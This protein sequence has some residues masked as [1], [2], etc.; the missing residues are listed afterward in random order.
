MKTSLFI[1]IFFSLC[2]F[3]SSFVQTKAQ[4]IPFEGDVERDIFGDGISYITVNITEGA[5][6]GKKIDAYFRTGMS[7]QSEVSNYSELGAGMPINMLIEGR[8]EVLKVKG[9]LIYTAATFEDPL[10]GNPYQN[11]VYRIKELFQMEPPMAAPNE[12]LVDPSDLIAESK[13]NVIKAWTGTY[14]NSQGAILTIKN[15]TKD[16]WPNVAVL[17]F[18][19]VLK[20]EGVCVNQEGE[21]HLIDVQGKPMND[22]ELPVQ[23]VKSSTGMSVTYSP[24]FFAKECMFQFDAEFIKK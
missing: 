6:K 15:S 7:D 21:L 18:N 23:F 3:F 11:N 10:N 5:L 8:S 16:N 17:D 22:A 13:N 14:T 1:Q 4:G 20:T 2:I 12:I 24:M 9:T 19:L